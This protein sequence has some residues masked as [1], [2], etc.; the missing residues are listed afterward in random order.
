MSDL[1]NYK[2]TL[3][4]DEGQAYAIKMPKLGPEPAFPPKQPK[5]KAAL[6]KFRYSTNRFDI[7]GHAYMPHQCAR[8][9]F[10]PINPEI[11]WQCGH[12]SGKGPNSLWCGRHAVDPVVAGTAVGKPAPKRPRT[13]TQTDLK[14]TIGAYRKENAD[15]VAQVAASDKRMT[16]YKRLATQALAV[17]EASLF[18][19][20]HMFSEFRH[21][22]K[23][24]ANANSR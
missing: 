18:K 14:N 3:R 23:E 6:A 8:I 21:L 19:G 9:I 13:R 24:L 16:L 17:A 1:K 2:G 4:H 12:R 10:D 7:F 20:Q 11:W 22:Q 5:S 15:L